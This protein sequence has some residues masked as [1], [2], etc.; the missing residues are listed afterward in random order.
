MTNEQLKEIFESRDVENYLLGAKKHYTE[1]SIIDRARIFNNL[2]TA[3]NFG[4]ESVSRNSL[5]LMVNLSFIFMLFPEKLSRFR[6]L[7]RKKIDIQNEGNIFF[8]FV[9]RIEELIRMKMGQ[10]IDTSKITFRAFFSDNFDYSSITTGEYINLFKLY[11]EVSKEKYK[12]SLYDNFG[13]LENIINS[14]YSW[15]YRKGIFDPKN[16]KY[17]SLHNL[18]IK[19]EDFKDK[20][21]NLVEISKIMRG[22][23]GIEFS[24]GIFIP[25]STRVYENFFDV[26][27]ENSYTDNSKTDLLE[28]YTK[29][30][31][32]DYFGEENVYLSNYDKSGKEQDI[33]VKYKDYVLLIECKSNN[34]NSIDGY[35]DEGERLLLE[36][37]EK[38]IQ[39]GAYQC[40]RAK[41]YIYN[42]E[43]SIFYDLPGKKKRTEIFRITRTNSKKI[44]KLV[45]T[46]KDFLNLAESANHFFH[47]NLTLNSK[48]K[49]FA[50][51]DIEDTWVVNVFALEKI[52]WKFQV[53][54][55]FIKYAEYRCSNIQDIEASS[56]DELVQVGY[57]ISPNYPRFIP[58]N[59]MGISIT[60]GNN[61]SNWVN[62]YEWYSL[63]KALE[64]WKFDHEN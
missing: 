6:R 20:K 50:K 43:P 30:M 59:G 33:I 48:T 53:K 19:A 25:K 44:I 55:E 24:Q 46:L 5:K 4:E 3:R 21:I 12:L 35:G 47:D 31:I 60:L 27:T 9:Y 37:F 36:K 1:I 16:K 58:R 56:S 63:Q 11:D 26:L 54:E 51:E 8:S 38:S 52:F 62:E 40:L 7:K 41:N 22:H 57:Y 61:F 18:F 15:I 34:F 10:E 64:V 42:N 29:R 2:I 39:Y 17:S 13:L 49:Y 32:S 23:I 14:P 28:N 45:V